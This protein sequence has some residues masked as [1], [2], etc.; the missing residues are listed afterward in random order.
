MDNIVFNQIA[1]L[2]DIRRVMGGVDTSGD[3]EDVV[4]PPPDPLIRDP[5]ECLPI[6]PDVRSFPR[7]GEQRCAECE[8]AYARLMYLDLA[9]LTRDAN[10]HRCQATCHKHNHKGDCR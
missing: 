8:A 3:V 9:S 2:A 6:A 1:T 10:W 4:Q 5:K 7:A